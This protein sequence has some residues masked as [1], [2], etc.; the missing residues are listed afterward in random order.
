MRTRS[1]D[2]R[3]DKSRGH[4]CSMNTLLPETDTRTSARAG[5]TASARRGPRSLVS[6]VWEAVLEG[7]R[8]ASRTGTSESERADRRPDA[9]QPRRVPAARRC[10]RSKAARHAARRTACGTTSWSLPAPRPNP[11]DEGTAPADAYR[12]DSSLPPRPRPRARASGSTRG[13]AR[14]RPRPSGKPVAP[15]RTRRVSGGA[16]ASVDSHSGRNY[17][18]R[19][20]LRC[21]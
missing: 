17:D 10:R 7:M 14:Q 8:Y 1:S 21:Q 11:R 9:R 19:K 15:G 18:A 16:S 5:R 3:R 13:T 6:A 12:P 4:G 20:R 2:T